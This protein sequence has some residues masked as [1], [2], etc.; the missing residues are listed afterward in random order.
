VAAIMATLALGIGTNTAVFAVACGYLVNPLPFRDGDRLTTILLTAPSIGRDRGPMSY[1]EFQ[2]LRQRSRCLSDVAAYEHDTVTMGGADEPRRLMAMRV[3]ANLVDVLG[4]KPALGRAFTAGDAGAGAPAVVVLPHGTWQTVFG[5]DRSA[6]GRVVAIDGTPHQIIGVMPAAGAFPAWAELLL[7]ARAPAGARRDLRTLR[8]VGRLAPRV[9]LDEARREMAAIS[10]DFAASFPAETKGYSI[11]IES[12]RDDLLDDRRPVLLLFY[13]VACLVLLLATANV[14]LLML[15]RG[16]AR[17]QETAI[18]ASLGA[19]RIRVARQL[20]VES[21]LL[22]AAGG[23]LGIIIGAWARDLVVASLPGHLLDYFRFD[24]SPS[25]LAVLAGLTL[26]TAI[27]AGL[28]SSWFSWRG[29]LVPALRGADDSGGQPVASRLRSWLVGFQVALAVM[30]LVTTG[31]MVKG[32][33]RLQESP[34]FNPSGVLTMEINLPQTDR[35]AEPASRHRFFDDLLAKVRRHPGVVRAGAANPMPYIGWPAAYEVEGVPPTDPRALPTAISAVATGGYF[36]TLE[37]PM[38]AGR[39]FDERDARPGALRVVIVSERFARANWPGAGPLGRRV[40]WRTERG[41]TGAWAEVVGVVGETRGGPFFAPRGWIYE[42]QAQL[43]ASELILAIRTRTDPAGIIAFVKQQVWAV[44]PG[45]PVHWNNI[46]ETQMRER[47]PEPSIY[48]SLLTVFSGF[49]LVLA[50]VGVYG[51]VAYS[52][53]RRTREFAVR[54]SVGATP[55]EVIALVVRQGCKAAAWGLTAGL[56]LT[57]VMVR[58]ARN[59]FYGVS[60]FDAAAYVMAGAVV[61]ACV[62]LA[63]YLP[64]RR[65]ARVHPLTALQWE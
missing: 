41:P 39:D 35:Y 1:G 60:P 26:G 40:R 4:T 25:E 12:L 43:A 17:R 28:A 61:A 64:A 44:E 11:L 52:V 55:R 57:L 18:R 65:A 62:L 6:V 19:S 34:G 9:G 16:A 21:L 20:M 63:S 22:A 45:L 48:A 27:V 51:V 36:A 24:L 37:A 59:L 46:L 23:T 31:L 33:L 30:V 32:V 53:A 8:L 3:S 58:L 7:P 10:A 56:A 2:D 29:N 38:L 54:I 42:P 13:A 50:V 15:A 5:G 14:A 47:Y 49:S